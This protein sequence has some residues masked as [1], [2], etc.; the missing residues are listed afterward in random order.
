M[1]S[2]QFYRA[3]EC[4][5]E[6]A[7]NTNSVRARPV[8]LVEV[9]NAMMGALSPEER[10]A[11]MDAKIPPT[12]EGFAIKLWGWQLRTG[13]TG[14]LKEVPKGWAIAVCTTRA[15][16]DPD[17]KNAW[18]ADGGMTPMDTM[19]A[20]DRLGTRLI[21]SVYWFQ[22]SGGIGRAYGF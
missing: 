7:D 11:A 3:D 9:A 19:H 17:G 20:Y 14:T 16:R 22:T 10:R 13:N 21:G 1:I 8:D 5:A 4:I 18:Q 12:V 2:Y 6:L 15:V